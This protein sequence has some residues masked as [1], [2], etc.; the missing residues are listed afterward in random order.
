MVVVRMKRRRIIASLGFL[1]LMGVAV[2]FRLWAI[3]YSISSDDSELLRRQFDIA[4]REAMDESAEWRLRYDQA[5][6]RESKCLQELQGIKGTNNKFKIL[7]K[8]NAILLERLETLKRE[9]E[10]QKLKCNSRKHS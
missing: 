4:N 2:Y 5:V 10:D 7:Q 1:M 9:V 6:D 3:H 8:E